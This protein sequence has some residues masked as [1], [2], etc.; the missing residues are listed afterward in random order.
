MIYIYIYK[1]L[2]KFFNLALFII[3]FFLIFVINYF[4]LTLA[5]VAFEPMIIRL[6]PFDHD[7]NLMAYAE[8]VTSFINRK[9]LQICVNGAGYQLVYDV[10]AK[11]RETTE[12]YNK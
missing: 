1:N 4:N 6:I 9:L 8:N 5:D 7:Q 10:N 11:S 2:K 3:F 12:S